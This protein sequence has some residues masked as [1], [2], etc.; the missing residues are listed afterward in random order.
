M[1]IAAADSSCIS[2]DHRIDAPI[3]QEIVAESERISESCVGVPRFGY[4][5]KQWSTHMELLP[6]IAD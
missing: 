1:K 6:T 5:T 3:L 4:P 2:H